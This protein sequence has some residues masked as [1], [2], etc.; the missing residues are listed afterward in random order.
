[1]SAP[2]TFAALGRRAS[3]PAPTGAKGRSGLIVVIVVVVLIGAGLLLNALTPQSSDEPLSAHN[4][5]AGGARAAAQILTAHGVDVTEVTTTQDTLADAGA[6]S[7]LLV[8]HADTLRPE[9]LQALAEVDS[10][11]V[12]IGLG[13][14]SIAD[15]TTMVQVNG[16]GAQA[17]YSPFC[18]DENAEAAGTLSTAGPGL[19]PA[20]GMEGCFPIL[21]ES[22]AFGTWTDERDRTW[23][24]LP[25]SYPLTNNGLDEVGNA[26]LILRILG[27]HEHLTWYVPDPADTFGLDEEAGPPALVPTV[28]TVQVLIAMLAFAF[29][30]G[31]RLGRVVVEPLPVIVRATETTRGRGRLYRR[32]GAYAHAASAL[33]AGTIARVAAGVGLPRTADGPAVVDALARAT[34]RPP[35]HIDS[36]LY[37]P[38]PTDDAALMA[39]TQALDTLESEVH[40]R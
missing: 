25:N 17:H 14:N 4:A 40:Q 19:L 1:M 15:L 3:D 26:A 20:D 35:T 2:P 6:G 21:E 10:D 22:Y 8:T 29:W 34:G 37:G 39:L 38:P 27:A 9:Q 24:V 23:S 36:L 31:R 30:R 11:I 32:A 18:S 12:L 16:G 33:R 7:T 13:Y 28:V 5:G